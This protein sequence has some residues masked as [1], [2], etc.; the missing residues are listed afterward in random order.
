MLVIRHTSSIQVNSKRKNNEIITKQQNNMQIEDIQQQAQKG[1]RSRLF[2]DAQ[3]PYIDWNNNWLNKV[4][5][6][7]R[8]RNGFSLT[9]INLIKLSRNTRNNFEL[10]TKQLQTKYLHRK[11][12]EKGKVLTN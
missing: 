7:N 11:R 6:I 9:N 8:V 12:K 1:Q 2:M 5:A 10:K 4:L 3:V